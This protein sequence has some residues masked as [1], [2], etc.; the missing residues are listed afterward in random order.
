M[1]DGVVVLAL[2]LALCACGSEDTATAQP[3]SPELCDVA[4]LRLPDGSCVRPGVPA[5][6]CAGG[7]VHDGLYGCDP[8]LPAA[9]CA[10][11]TIALPGE[12]ECR[13]ITPCG[14]GPWGE[15]PTDGATVYVDAAYSAGDSDGSAAKPFAT[16]GAAVTA[17][18]PGALIAIAQGSYAE[19]VSVV[20]KPLRLWGRCPD[21]VEIVGQGGDIGAVVVAPGADGSEVRGLALRGPL[22]GIV[23]S[24]VA[25]VLLDSLWIHD[26]AIFA[27]LMTAQLG[28]TARRVT[29]VLVERA[30]ELGVFFAG[31]SVEVDGLN[32]RATLPG[33]DLTLGRGV[34]IDLCKPADGCDPPVPANVVMNRSL[35]DGNREIGIA[36][37]GST[38]AI[39]GTVVRGTLPRQS[40]L[41]LGRGIN[42]GHCTAADGCPLPVAPTASIEGVVVVGNSAVGILSEGAELAVTNSVVRDTLPQAADLQFGRGIEVQPCTA[43]RGCTPARPGNLLLERSLIDASHSAGL[44]ISAA[45]AQLRGIVV[46][47]TLPSAADQLSGRGINVQGCGA[48]SGCDVV[49][50]PTMTMFDSL[51]EDSRE[52]G[53]AALGANLELADSVIRASSAQV[54]DGL[55][56]D[57]LALSNHVPSAAATLTHVALRDSA[58]AGI[59][60]FGSL[61]SL[62]ST[63]I[64]CA[65]IELDGESHFGSDATFDDRGDNLCGCPDGSAACKVVSS[66]LGPPSPLETP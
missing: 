20:G 45:D 2:A 24:G 42:V 53:V 12:A 26:T 59:A 39:R 55:F 30:G 47:G 40:D 31:A 16:I 34:Q 52:F 33:A 64:E 49:I 7:F 8:V 28:P 23:V 61:V 58:R 60:N 37:A 5:D 3:P 66:G 21:L 38:A 29:N 25:E 13:A 48:E 46:R 63:S 18:A 41:M 56:G 35:I 4:D 17:A 62:G 65:A 32:V 6:G 19:D 14:E 36:V 15:V 9:A 27:I 1:R 51:I 57:G 44:F 10:D 11:A 22:A 54:A 43:G 50:A